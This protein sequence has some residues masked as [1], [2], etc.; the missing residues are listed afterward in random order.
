MI[1]TPKEKK[2][3][4]ITPDAV[5]EDYTGRKVFHVSHPS[6]KKTLRVSAPD[7]ASAIVAAAQYWKTTWR[8]YEFYAYCNVIPG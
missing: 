2:E 1:C 7:E 4:G 5:F 6:H 8:D 3:S